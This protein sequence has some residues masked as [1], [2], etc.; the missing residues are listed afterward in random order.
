MKVRLFAAGVMSILICCFLAACDRH[1][2]EESDRA[3]LEEMHQDIVEFVGEPT[4]SGS[5]DCRFI[6][7]GA[8]PCGGPWEYLIYSAS[9]VDTL[10]LQH[11]VETY[12][13]FNDELNRRYGW[14]SECSVPPVPNLDCR[15]GRC[16]DLGR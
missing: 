11:M 2:T 16:V 9:T 7:F 14:V 12:N 4:C 13:R 10:E 3:R 5:E 8:K 6:A 15:E 1:Y